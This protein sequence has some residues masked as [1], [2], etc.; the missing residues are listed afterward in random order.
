MTTGPR[1]YTCL[2]KGNRAVAGRVAALIGALMPARH[3]LSDGE[4]AAR[5]RGILILLWLHAVGLTAFGLYRG[6]GVYPS[7]GAGALIALLAVV[8]RWERIG[9]GARSVVA[10][11]GLLTCSAVLVM[12]SGGYIEAHFHFFIMVA[13]IAMYEDLIPYLFMLLYV[14]LEHGII[15]E[16]APAAVYNH[17][18]ALAH[19]W[20]WGLIHTGFILAMAVAVQ[21]SWRVN[22]RARART[23]LV[24]NSA[25][26]GI[27]GLDL[28]GTITFANSAAAH[29]TGY[30]LDALVGSALH[31]ILKDPDGT[32][33]SCSFDPVLSSRDKRTCRCVDKLVVRRDGTTLFPVDVVCNPIV[34]RGVNVGTVA[35][36]KDETY[37]R[38]AQEALQENEERLRQMAESIAEVFWMSSPDKRQMIYVSPA[39]ETIWGRSCRSVYAEPVSWLEAIHEQDRARISRAALEKQI[40]GDYDEEYRI[41]RGD[42]AVRWIRDRAF[43]VRNAQG[44][45]YRI[46]GVAAD[47]TDYKEAE[48]AIH[49]ANKRLA[50]V[51]ASLERR[52]MERTVELEAV[53]RQV[54]YEKQKTERIIHEITDG[55]ILIDEA[56][57]IILI[58]PAA[59]AQLLGDCDRAVPRNIYEVTRNPNLLATFENPVEASTRE[60]EVYDERSQETRVFTTTA[61][62]LMDEGGE[63]LGKVAVLHDIT[64][65]K[66]V[67]RLKSEF[68]SQVSHELRTPLT[69]IKGYIDNL[70]DGLAGVLTGKQL[71]Y[72]LRM[73]KNADHLVHLINDLLDV[74]RIE[75]G[76]MRLNRT[77]VSMRALILEVIGVLQPLAAARDLTVE[78]LGLEQEIFLY[79]DG[80]K[81]EQVLNNLLDNAIKFTPPGGRITIKLERDPRLVTITVRDTGIGIAAQDQAWIFERFYRVEHARGP[82]VNGT[83]LGLYISKTIVEMHGGMLWVTSEAGRGSEFAFALPANPDVSLMPAEGEPS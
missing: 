6:V 81:L 76:K 30:P 26:E 39:Y 37:R 38:Q 65:Y 22:Q 19:P 17:P 60:V 41:V 75:S 25:G 35:T 14:A 42:G 70:K 12:L 79:G 24:L 82:T 71:G 36:L 8:A 13:V 3:A 51:N 69:S 49:A 67:D 15:G 54:S 23:D 83:G 4:W 66:E 18:A 27:V 48:E 11:T 74:S 7:L 46:A 61:V 80:G 21:A 77:M 62:P 72:L 78:P 55:V 10:S 40:A 44:E 16:V 34:E 63:F 56:G 43:P 45:I 20:K 50:E 1:V 58:N 32:S 53:L 57:D 73:S 28:N 68:I 33:P 59:R 9:R 47:I 52:V 29:M 31:R 64:S 2:V 5:H